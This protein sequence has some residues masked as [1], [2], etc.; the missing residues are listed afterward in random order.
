M[1]ASIYRMQ[2]HDSSTSYTIV[3]LS[4]RDLGLN[5]ERP[6]AV[7]PTP[8]A[9]GAKHLRFGA[10]LRKP[11]KMS[12]VSHA[13]LRRRIT[14]RGDS[15]SQALLQYC[16]LAYWLTIMPACRAAWIHARTPMS[17]TQSLTTKVVN[18]AAP[19]YLSASLQRTSHA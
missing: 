12:H 14:S 15:H 9:H 16:F 19:R 5:A 17:S 2:S 10:G 6:G 18:E 13:P 3:S 8:R 4:F 11:V 7:G 1:T